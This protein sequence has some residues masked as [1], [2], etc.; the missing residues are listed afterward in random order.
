M[1]QVVGERG[2]GKMGLHRI[3]LLEME[4]WLKGG[5]KS[6]SFEFRWCDGVLTCRYTT[7]P[8]KAVC[9]CVCVCVCERE[10]GRERDGTTHVDEDVHGTVNWNIIGR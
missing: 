3:E 9:M 5:P 1:K 2:K 6:I 8:V 10:R 7:K 4:K